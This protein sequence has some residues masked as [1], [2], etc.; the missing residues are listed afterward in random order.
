[1]YDCIHFV[2]GSTLPSIRLAEDIE[3]WMDGDEHIEFTVSVE[4]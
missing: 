3:W 2:G 1:M 4:L